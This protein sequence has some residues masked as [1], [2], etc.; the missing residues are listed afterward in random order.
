MNTDWTPLHDAARDGDVARLRRVLDAGEVSVDATG[1]RGLSTPLKYVSI[2]WHH[3]PPV[4]IDD[5]VACFKLLRDAGANLEV[6]DSLGMTPLHNVAK[7][8]CPELLSLLIQ[9]GVCVDVAD[10][11]GCTPLH[12]ASTNGHVSCVDALL[13]AGASVHAK[14]SM[15]AVGYKGQPPLAMALCRNHRRV[16]PLLLRAGAPIPPQDYNG[17]Y[18]WNSQ[19]YIKRIKRAG[20][21]K[22]YEQAHLARLTAILE[23]PLLPPELVRKILEFWLHAGYY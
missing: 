16:W 1:A 7:D 3:R 18:Y 9:S 5:R 17:Q 22:K 20:G 8:G 21:I 6:A 10:V 11:D 2:K 23:T 19:P 14:S 12:W 15:D 13:A 4:S